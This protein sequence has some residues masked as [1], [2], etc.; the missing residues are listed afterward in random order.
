M[1]DRVPVLSVHRSGRTREWDRSAGLRWAA[2]GSAGHR[3][4]HSREL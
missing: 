2:C 1:A 3:C 4:R